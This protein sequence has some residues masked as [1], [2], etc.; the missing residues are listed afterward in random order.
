[1]SSTR[2]SQELKRLAA[3]V[4]PWGKLYPWRHEPVE[5]TPALALFGNLL[6]PD[7][8]FWLDLSIGSPP[9]ALVM[10]NGRGHML[11]TKVFED[12]PGL[13]QILQIEARPP[14]S[15]MGT[16]FMEAMRRYA[17]LRGR[18]FCVGLVANRKF[19]RRFKWLFPERGERDA[20]TWCY[21]PKS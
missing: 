8:E 5:P 1:M 20:L 2:E 12:D 6:P 18:T 19:F 16:V 4:P 11:A 17:D 9:P 3:D 7:W 14:G 10:R 15:G 21:S 13:T